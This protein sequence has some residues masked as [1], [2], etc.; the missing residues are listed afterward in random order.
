MSPLNITQP[1]SVYGQ[2]HGYFFR[3]CPILPKWVTNP[4]TCPIFSGWWYTYPSEKYESQLGWWH[5]QYME[6][7]KI[8]V[9]NH[10][11]VFIC[12][13][14]SDGAVPSFSTPRRISLRS[15]RC[16]SKTAP[17]T[18]AGPG[19]SS[20]WLW[21]TSW[22]MDWFKGKFTQKYIFDGKIYGFL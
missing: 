10:Q 14:K 16:S 22:S 2:C 15:S 19:P 4:W 1:K 5:S 3:W 8:H 6:S 9:P 21:K 18:M 20:L 12:L 13:V 17:R 7:H 11:P